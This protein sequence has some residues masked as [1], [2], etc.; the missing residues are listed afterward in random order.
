MV[1]CLGGCDG[2]G[3]RDAYYRAQNRTTLEGPDTTLKRC[4]TRTLLGP[5]TQLGW[6]NLVSFRSCPSIPAMARQ[7]PK[8]N[9]SASQE[10][11]SSP[12]V[13]QSAVLAYRLWSSEFDRRFWTYK[14][15]ICACHERPK[16]SK[17][18]RGVAVLCWQPLIPQELENP[19]V[20]FMVHMKY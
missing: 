1:P 6:N 7:E 10:S 2:F 18:S 8:T 19:Q 16:T 3:F 17:A 5:H 15:S 9:P 20:G 4:G 14:T 13:S 11:P 12:T